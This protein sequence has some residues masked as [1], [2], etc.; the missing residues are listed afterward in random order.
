MK[1]EEKV[2]VVPTLLE[3]SHQLT[4]PH[5]PDWC[6]VPGREGRAGEGTEDDI[7]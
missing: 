3:S 7:G 1:D 6:R 4:W 2:L 5:I